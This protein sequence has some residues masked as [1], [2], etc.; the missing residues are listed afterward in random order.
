MGDTMKQLGIDVLEDADDVTMGYFVR[1][2]KIYSLTRQLMEQQAELM[3][4]MNDK[5]DLLMDK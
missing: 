4:S 5:L 2:M 3:E 1:T